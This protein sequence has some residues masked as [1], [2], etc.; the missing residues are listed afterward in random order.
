MQVNKSVQILPVVK[1]KS[2]TF[3]L[4]FHFHFSFTTG[5]CCEIIEVYVELVKKFEFSPPFKRDMLVL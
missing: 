1:K 3:F 2:K 5:A 4:R